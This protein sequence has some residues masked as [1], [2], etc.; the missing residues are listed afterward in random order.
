MFIAAFENTKKNSLLFAA[1]FEFN[2][3]ST[4]LNHVSGRYKDLW[5]KCTNTDLP[6]LRVTLTVSVRCVLW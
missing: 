2:A 4:L 1:N 6:H 5:A 3:R